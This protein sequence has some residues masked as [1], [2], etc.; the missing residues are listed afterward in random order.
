MHCYIYNKY[1]TTLQWLNDQEIV[2]KLICY[3]HPNADPEVCN[4]VH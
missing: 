2:K 4:H 3:I 1:H